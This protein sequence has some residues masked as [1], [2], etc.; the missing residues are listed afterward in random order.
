M[1]RSKEF[2]CTQFKDI[3]LITRLQI[4]FI[5]R[6]KIQIHLQR[7]FKIIYMLDQYQGTDFLVW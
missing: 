1:F 6:G 2:M 4:I 3:F 5:K 7:D